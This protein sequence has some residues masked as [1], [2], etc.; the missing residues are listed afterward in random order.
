[1]NISQLQQKA[2]DS[3]KALFEIG[4]NV[5]IFV[6]ARTGTVFGKVSSFHENGSIIVTLD[7]G[8]TIVEHP[9]AVKIV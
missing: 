6:G 3:N 2:I 8:K 7:N 4:Q 9:L 1:M 5:S